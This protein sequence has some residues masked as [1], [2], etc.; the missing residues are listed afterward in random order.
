MGAFPDLDDYSKCWPVT[1]LIMM[2]LKY[3]SSRARLR[4]SAE[5]ARRSPTALVCS[6]SLTLITLTHT[7]QD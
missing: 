5:K 6:C 4:E 2:R 1:D 3:T 7:M